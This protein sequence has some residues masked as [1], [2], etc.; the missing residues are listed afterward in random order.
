MKKVYKPVQPMKRQT[1]EIDAQSI[2]AIGIPAAPTT[3][4]WSTYRPAATPNAHQETMIAQAIE[5]LVKVENALVA[6]SVV[7]QRQVLAER[8]EQ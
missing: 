4:M 3:G 8:A 5:K 2:Y 7:E 6:D 1:A